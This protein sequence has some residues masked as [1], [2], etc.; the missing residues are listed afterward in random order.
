MELVCTQNCNKYAKYRFQKLKLV[1]IHDKSNRKFIQVYEVIEQSK[2]C[3]DCGELTPTS[4]QHKCYESEPQN[5][6]IREEI[7]A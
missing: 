4:K 3:S 7:V 5:S 1:R 6:M 2:P